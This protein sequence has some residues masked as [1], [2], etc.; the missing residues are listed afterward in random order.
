MSTPG[1]QRTEISG[2]PIWARLLLCPC[3]ILAAGPLPLA[4]AGQL[5][6]YDGEG[7]CPIND[8]FAVKSRKINQGIL[9][10]GH[11]LLHSCSAFLCTRCH[12]FFLL[13]S[14]LK[15]R[16]AASITLPVHQQHCQPAIRNEAHASWCDITA[17]RGLGRALHGRHHCAG[18]CARSACCHT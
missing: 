15:V 3:Q 10:S 5:H 1:N 13:G 12:V 8:T 17:W 6:I 2:E 4:V 11:L 18:L 16:H 14:R 9:V 7:S